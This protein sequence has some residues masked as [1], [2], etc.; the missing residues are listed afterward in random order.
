MNLKESFRYQNFLE[1][2][3]KEARFSITASEHCLTTIKT[4][5]MKKANAEA[6]DIIEQV[7]VDEFPANNDVIAYLVWLVDEKAKLTSAI[8]KAKE[9]LDFCLDAAIETNKFRQSI[10]GSIQTMLRFAPTKK[11]EKGRDYKFNVEGNQTPYYYDVEI[12]TKE[13]FDRAKSKSIMRELITKA[14]EVST[15]IDL[16]MINTM[17]DYEPLFDVNETF[18]DIMSEFKAKFLNSTET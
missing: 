18:E 7:Q 2:Q 4:H 1:D 15:Q 16:A 13:A 10:S 8:S 5:Q 17:V 6:E 3:L 11:I 14:D 9:S 12:T